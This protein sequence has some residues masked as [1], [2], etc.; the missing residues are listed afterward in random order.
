MN[1]PATTST[2]LSRLKNSN[3]FD[4][5]WYVT[6]YTDVLHGHLEAADHYLKIG[7][8]LGRHPSSQ[9][10]A[11]A[12]E[13]AYPEAMLFPG[14]ALL[15]YL[16]VGQEKNHHFSPV[17]SFAV[18]TQV[19][20]LHRES[21]HMDAHLRARIADSMALEIGPKYEASAAIIARAFD[22]EFYVIRHPEVLYSGLNPIQ[23]YL[24][25]GAGKNF[26]PSP[27]FST[28]MY[29]TRAHDLLKSGTNPFV[30]WLQVGLHNGR[31]G[32]PNHK[33]PLIAK[34]LLGLKAPEVAHEMVERR[35]DLLNRLKYG[36][37]GEMVAGATELDPL[38][39][40][41]WPEA[42]AP[43][44]PP[45]HTP[46]TSD[47]LDALCA[48]RDAAGYQRAQF[49]LAVNR[50]RWG[51]GL[52]EEG[53]LAKFLSEAYG[54]ESVLIIYTDTNDEIT[55][56][57]F[58]P[59]IRQVSLKTA[60]KGS[61]EDVAI[62]VLQTFLRSLRPIA[63]FNINSRLSW[64]CQVTYQAVMSREMKIYNYLFCNEKS[65]LGTWVGY[66]VKYVYRCFDWCEE[67]LVDSHFLKAELIE[68]FALPEAMHARIR[69]IS[70]PVDYSV[71]LAPAPPLKPTRPR[72]V[73]WSGRFARQKRLD[74]LPQI[75]MR[76][77]DV[78]FR[79]WGKA[80]LGKFD[81][82]TLAR[83]NIVLE[84]SYE[85]FSDL[86]L[87]ECD[88][89]LYTSEWDGVPHLLLEVCMTGIPIV[90]SV[91]GGT[92]EVL[93]DDLSW[94]VEDID[95]VDAYVAALRDI[96]GRSTEARACATRLREQMMKERD[97]FELTTL[98]GSF[99]GLEKENGDETHG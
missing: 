46:R 63:F 76:M 94:P 89:W 43:K 8:R 51:C 82:S 67:L 34:Q 5:E 73:F 7:G 83:H 99:A 24:Q 44:M 66:P 50:P 53:Y 41:S 35:T 95:D 75:A 21:W 17:T 91:V 80:I 92:S 79:V 4:A 3:L 38:I 15:H 59:A 10:D 88:A 74:L 85:T 71:A 22:P 68:R 93:K 56:G 11:K 61:A 98:V 31:L 29:K 48:L 84:G 32:D 60:T 27:H 6:A 77:P 87:E 97:N 9:F 14:G 65:V 78:I 81:D 1:L 36:K 86:P 26:N 90:G 30:H 37:L 62:D 57:R 45:F 12:Y 18:P 20:M 69:V 55:P 23:H 28:K 72:Q 40:A 25:I 52:K 19:P 70:A 58:D 96:L 49:V 47:K 54:P 16:K 2:D 42:F 64:V 33:L 13:K 39:G